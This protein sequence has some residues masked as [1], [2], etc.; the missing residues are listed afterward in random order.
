MYGVRVID[1]CLPKEVQRHI[2][3]MVVSLDF[4]LYRTP[5]HVTKDSL[6]HWGEDV[7]INGYTAKNSPQYVHKFFWDDEITSN[8]Y[9]FIF[10]LL[11]SAFPFPIAN[12]YRAK[13]NHVPKMCSGEYANTCGIP[14]CDAPPSDRISAIYYVNDSDG[15][16]VIFNQTRQEGSSKVLTVDQEIEPRQGRLVIFDVDR[17]HASNVPLVS[18]HRTVINIVATPFLQK[19]GSLCAV[20]T[21]RAA[22]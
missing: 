9:Q 16:T 19:K 6:G 17:I 2:E 14:H 21:R 18:Q 15:K 22:P 4:P 3:D 10:P 11:F 13:L 7:K 12:V 5:E 1:D 20:T 8:Y